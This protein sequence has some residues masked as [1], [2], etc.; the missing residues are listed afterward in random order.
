MFAKFLVTA[1]NLKKLKIKMKLYLANFT[2]LL[3]KQFTLFFDWVRLL[4]LDTHPNFT[5]VYRRP[6]PPP[7]PRK[8]SSAPAPAVPPSTQELPNIL[9]H[10]LPG[11]PLLNQFS[12]EV[13]PP[14]GPLR[15]LSSKVLAHR[16]ILALRPNWLKKLANDWKTSSSRGLCF[17]YM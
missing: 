4:A 6:G 17:G 13:A 1:K 14:M 8:S 11:D 5:N 2:I 15:Q 16:F 10:L 12:S 7:P 9:L 3:K